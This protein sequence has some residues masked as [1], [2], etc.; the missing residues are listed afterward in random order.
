M[1]KPEELAAKEIN[2]DPRTW[3]N[4]IKLFLVLDLI[5]PRAL[6]TSRD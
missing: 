2:W 3:I 1:E 6:K 4:I 5:F